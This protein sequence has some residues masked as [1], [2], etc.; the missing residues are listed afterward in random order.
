MKRHQ[1]SGAWESFSAFLNS[2]TALS[3][4]AMCVNKKYCW[5]EDIFLGKL[6]LGAFILVQMQPEILMKHGWISWILKNRVG[7]KAKKGLAYLAEVN[8]SFLRL[9]SDH[10]DCVVGPCCR[11]EF[12]LLPPDSSRANGDAMESI[13]FP[14]ASKQTRVAREQAKP[15]LPDKILCAACLSLVTRQSWLISD[16]I[17]VGMLS[18]KAHHP[19][20]LISSSKP[21]H[22]L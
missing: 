13:Y 17:W 2:P 12:V 5:E 4:I 9:R 16:H 20:W 1:K 11:T 15:C 8:L 10:C 22:A 6:N 18:N 14:F 3:T 7:K 21:K 19:K